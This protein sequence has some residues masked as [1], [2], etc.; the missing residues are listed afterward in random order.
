MEDDHTYSGPCHSQNI[1]FKYFQGYLGIFRD[2]GVYTGT[3]KGAQLGRS[4]EASPVFFKSALILERNTLIVTIF[5]LNF[6]FKM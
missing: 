1:E 4:G 2:I 3:L 5:G 6:P